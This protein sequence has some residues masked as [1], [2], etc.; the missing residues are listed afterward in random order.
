MRDLRTLQ[1]NIRGA[2][3]GFSPQSGRVYRQFYS[4]PD[5]FKC[6][7]HSV[8]AYRYDIQDAG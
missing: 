1:F 3:E 7:S 6:G 5:L 4:T 2:I 8:R